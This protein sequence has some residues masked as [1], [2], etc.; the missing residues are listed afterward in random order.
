MRHA[1]AAAGSKHS[2]GTSV[3]EKS[4]E[5]I[6]AET[7]VYA[8]GAKIRPSWRCS[9]KIGR[10]AMMMISIENSVGRPTCSRRLDESLR[11]TASRSRVPARSRQVAEDVLDHDHRA[12]HDDAEIHRAEREQVRRDAA[13]GA[14]R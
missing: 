3:S 7:M 4:S 12:V 2:S 1:A 9:V 10:C 8:I 5:P 13:D 11:R 6:S 14:G